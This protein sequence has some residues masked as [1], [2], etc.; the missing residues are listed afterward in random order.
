MKKD[1]KTTVFGTLATTCITLATLE[2]AYQVY[3]A[4]AG[5]IFGAIFSLVSTD[6][7]SSVDIQSLGGSNPP[8]KK[9]ER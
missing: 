4:A 8:T 2:T 5:I 6:A 9:D 3:F 1:W 7:K